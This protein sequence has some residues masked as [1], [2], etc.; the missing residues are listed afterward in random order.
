M[1]MTFTS[2]LPDA[3]FASRWARVTSAPCGLMKV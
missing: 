2:V 3:K 1:S